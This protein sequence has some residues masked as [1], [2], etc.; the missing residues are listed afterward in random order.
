M[1]QIKRLLA[2]LSV[3]QRWTILIAGILAAAGF[4]GLAHWQTENSFRPLYNAL[5]P[6]DAAVVVQKLKEGGTP[7]RLSSNN[8]TISVPEDKVA[9]LRLEMAG[10]GIP[11]NGRIG[12]EIFDKTNFGMT[13]FAEHINYRRALEG[14]LERSVMSISQVEQA[15]VHISFPQ[16]SVFTEARQPAKA[17]VLVKIRAGDALPDSAVPAI[18]NLISSAVEGLAP[19]SV[20]VL[21][22]RGNLLNRAKRMNGSGGEDLSDSALEYRHK[23]EQDLTAKL[24]STLEPL[25]GAGRFRASVSADCDLSSGEQSEESFDPT[26]S[27]MVSSQTT[28]DSSSTTR[29]VEGGIPG[30]ASNLPESAPKPGGGG[31]GTSRKTENVNYETSRTV[32]RTV[33]PQGAIKRLSVSV[34]IDQEA[35][36]E[37]AGAAAKRILVPPAPERMKV[38][39]DL[40]AA[41]TGLNMERGDQLI[42]ESLP[43]ESTLNLDP[44]GGPEDAASVAGVNGKKPSL[45]EQVKSEPKLMIGAGATLVVLLGGCFFVIR[46]LTKGSAG[47]GVQAYATPVLPQAAGEAGASQVA[48]ASGAAEL[49]SWTPSHAAASPLPAL[50]PGRIEVLTKNLR[51]TAQK[52]AEICAGVLRGWLKEERT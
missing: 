40:A 5:A 12:F 26:H 11:K 24:N 1:E 38:I 22:M 18:T 23:V 15:R 49:D 31:S 44:P 27:V 39:H 45:L 29:S 35:R 3:R 17:S 30:T 9:E 50:A 4:Y 16:E 21:D 28:Q 8:S 51:E 37:G 36:W 13:D 20:S 48:R 25:V 7:Y 14:E 19:E 33:L 42:V 34:L 6:D 2:A 43:F 41:A 10:A 32:K 46:G 47:K 52:D